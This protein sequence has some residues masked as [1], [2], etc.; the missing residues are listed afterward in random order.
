MQPIPITPPPTVV[1]PEGIKLVRAEVIEMF[2]VPFLTC[3]WEVHGRPKYSAARC[4]ALTVLAEDAYWI[5]VL[6]QL[7]IHLETGTCVTSE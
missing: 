2:G 3:E 7:Q 4:P 5:D 6:K 1:F